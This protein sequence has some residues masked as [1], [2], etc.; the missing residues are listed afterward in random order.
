MPISA[1]TKITPPHSAVSRSS[2]A[3]GVTPCTRFVVVLEIA[4]MYALPPSFSAP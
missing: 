3:T 1:S 4:V 2:V